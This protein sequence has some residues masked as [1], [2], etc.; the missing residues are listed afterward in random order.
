MGIYRERAIFKMLGSYGVK[1]DEKI[2]ASCGE[3]NKTY[4]GAELTEKELKLDDDYD[5][6]DNANNDNGNNDNNAYGNFY[7]YRLTYS[8]PSGHIVLGADV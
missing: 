6:D 3:C 2:T 4:N 1:I 8:C 7:K 5:N